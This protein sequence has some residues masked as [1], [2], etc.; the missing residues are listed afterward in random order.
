[1]SNTLKPRTARVVIYDGEDLEQLAA[2]DA[3]VERATAVDDTGRKPLEIA[4]RQAER[5]LKSAEL[6]AEGQVRLLSDDDPLAAVRAERDDAQDALNQF[7]SKAD[8]IKVERDDFAAAAEARGKTIVLIARPRLRWRELMREHPPRD[9]EV[10]DIPLGVNMETLPDV[11]VP[12]SV[13]LAM[14]SE[15]GVGLDVFLDALSDFD[16][17][18]RLFLTAFALNR[19]S[20]AADPT[21]RLLYASSQI[22]TAISS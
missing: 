7:E 14:S 15:L 6:A 13:D 4:L 21:Q 9:D 11:L 2:L 12:E 22:S 20:A 16:Y 8:P 1:M 10:A 17:Y 18:D 19:G 5:R 3:A